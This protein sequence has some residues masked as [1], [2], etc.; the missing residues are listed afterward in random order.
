MLKGL[1]I[2]KDTAVQ[3]YLSPSLLAMYVDTL[4]MAIGFYMLVPLLSVYFI[5]HLHWS[6]SLT[7]LILAVSGISQNGL[8]FFCGLLADHIGY[9]RAILLGVGI[10]IIGFVLY[11]VVSHPVGFAIAAFISGIGGAFFHP[12]SFGAYAR[13]TSEE[14]KTKIFSI[15]ETLSNIGFILGPVIGM[16]LLQFDF[17]IVSFCSAF[18]FILAFLLSWLLLPEMKGSSPMKQEFIPIVKKIGKNTR[19]LLFCLLIIGVWSLNVQL[20]LAVPVRAEMLLK[21]VDQVAYLYMAGA[22]FMVVL[23]IPLLQML[24]KKLEQLHVMALGTIILGTSMLMFGFTKGLWSMLFAVLLFTVGQMMVVPTMNH[25]ISSYADPQSF[26]T[27][28]G[29]TGW[30]FALG[31]L[32][33]NMGGGFLHDYFRLQEN[34]TFI[35]WIILFLFSCV[36]SISFFIDGSSEKKSTP[37]NLRT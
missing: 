12:A 8:R 28:F 10:R 18:M 5:H 34:Y 27:Y 35:P 24:S 11:G 23:Q 9:K 25:L 3:G 14:M 21:D 19:F 26:A 22:I 36:I 30:S 13:I 20:Y 16:F 1:K 17:T 15:R 4:L 29:F 31:G 2:K 37:V 7:G 33:G 6:I 32:L